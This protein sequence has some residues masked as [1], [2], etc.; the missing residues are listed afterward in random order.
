MFYNFPLSSKSL[1]DLKQKVSTN[2]CIGFQDDLGLQKHIESMN[3]KPMNRISSSPKPA[4]S[5]FKS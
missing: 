1:G 5:S 2:V 3:P 4:L